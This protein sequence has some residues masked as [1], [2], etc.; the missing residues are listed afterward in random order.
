MKVSILSAAVG[1]ALLGSAGSAL[2]LDTTNYAG[3]VKLYYGGATATDNLLVDFFRAVGGPCDAGTIDVYR[4]TNEAVILCTVSTAISGFGSHAV[5]FHKESNGGSERGVGPLIEYGRSGTNTTLQWLDLSK[6]D[7]TEL[8]TCGSSPVAG[9]TASG[10][11][12]L[13]SYTNHAS[14]PLTG[15]L[16]D[17]TGGTSP[18]FP[19]G[20]IADV[21]PALLLPKPS[22]SDVNTYLVQTAGVQVVFGVPVTTSLYRALQQAQ[23]ITGTGSVAPC[24]TNADD[25]ACVPS[26]TRSQLAALYSQTIADWGSFTDKNGVSLT[27]S[28]LVTP[29]LIPTD[30]VP[31]ICRRVQ[32]SGTE[33]GT[34]AYMLNNRCTDGTAPMALPDVGTV[35]DTVNKPFTVGSG[36]TT[37]IND[38][39]VQAGVGSGNVRSCL[40]QVEHNGNTDGTYAGNDRKWGIGVLSTE[41]TAANQTA[42]HDSI[43]FVAINGSAPTLANTINGDYDFYTDDVL[44][45]ISTGH[46]GFVD[47]TSLVGKVQGFLESHLALPA[48]I[49][50]VDKDYVQAWGQ[51]GLLSPPGHGT[52]AT[53]PVSPTAA[54][55]NPNAKASHVATGAISNCGPSIPFEAS[56]TPADNK[57]QNN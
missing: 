46:T 52:S 51:G 6:L 13:N 31:R 8:T 17:L 48:V 54:A 35:T 32:T 5:A 30:T 16:T 29:S 12:V 43:R 53:A 26:L 44:L 47:P 24:S 27:A 4:G 23:G 57:A 22:P 21:E 14:C 3:A 49:A 1:A 25:P 41:V 39:Y 10:V 9:V 40:D 36:G 34:E 11:T 45:K 2:A 56:G 42:A 19:T 37:T 50:N 18:V 15:N 38:H 55:S 7:S 20:G 28:T 33:A